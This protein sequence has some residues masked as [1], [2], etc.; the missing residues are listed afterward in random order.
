[1]VMVVAGAPRVSCED[2]DFI[3]EVERGGRRMDMQRSRMQ[4]ECFEE[5]NRAEE[6]F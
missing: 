6:T 5:R 3:L 1:M 2:D 4:E